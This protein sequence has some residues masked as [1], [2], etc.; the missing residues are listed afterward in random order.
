LNFRKFGLRPTHLSRLISGDRFSD[1]K[2]SL[3]RCWV[4]LL[5]GDLSV[6]RWPDKASK[7]KVRPEQVSAWLSVALVL[8]VL[9]VGVYW[10]MRIAQISFP[11]TVSAKGVLFYESGSDQA[12]RSLFGEKSFDASRLVLR[13]VVI[14]GAEG[15]ANQGMALIEV[16][17]KPAEAVS[18]GEMVP[19]GIR[20]EKIS[21]EGVVVNYQGK[22]ISLQQ[23]FDSASG[24]S[25]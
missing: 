16:D 25:Q 15:G 18:V 8:L 3:M 1:V 4:K 21:P 11:S 10:V 19:P 6:G 5:A 7:L 13:G 9:G 2:A 20:L 14:T 23:S 24:K 12:V 22:E 17:G